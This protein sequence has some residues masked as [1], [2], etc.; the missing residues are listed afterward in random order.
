MKNIRFHR[1]SYGIF[2]S[3]FP[4]LSY[5]PGFLILTPVIFPDGLCFPETPYFYKKNKRWK[6]KLSG[7]EN[8]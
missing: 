6:N 3:A 1:I 7:R 5:E 4:G 8:R 2:L